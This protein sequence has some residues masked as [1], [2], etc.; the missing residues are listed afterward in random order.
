MSENWLVE[1]LKYFLG[2]LNAPILEL[3]GSKISASSI[4]ISAAILAAS[5]ALAKALG[6]AVN[7]SLT[8]RSVDSG[9]RDS[10]ER[11]TRYITIFVGILFALN[12][13]GF[14]LNSLTALS[15]V[16]MVGIGFGLQNI[17]QNFISGII[18][19]VE[20]PVKV[21]DIIHVGDSVGKIIDIHV[22]ST[23]ILTRDD[24]A[25]IV[26]NSKLV[27]EEVMN[28]SFT[29][30]RIRQHIK[31]G[32]AYGSDVE[33]VRKI[34]LQQASEHPKVLK[35]PLPLVIFED[36]GDS[37]LDFDLRFWCGD[38]WGID[39]VCSDIRFQIDAAFRANKV[40]IPFPQ[41]DVH[42][43]RDLSN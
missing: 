42:L 18:L 4:I 7:R 17:T 13:L 8:K 36:F 27:S 33:K 43:F 9:I 26:P 40:Q 28:D 38:I 1:N 20:R 3:S 39:N 21:G 15:A 30:N 37:S 23:V 2:I 35:D 29:G 41:R 34:L 16:L 11:F 14:S 10:L 24:V 31:V 5:F 25:I 6:S 12:V 19:L 22:R 32:V